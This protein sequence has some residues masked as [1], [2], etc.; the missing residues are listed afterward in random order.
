MSIHLQTY[1]GFSDGTSHITQNF[2]FVAYAIYS[3]TDELVSIHGIWLGQKTNN[4]EE[5][6]V[7]IE[8]L[9]NAI[10]FGIH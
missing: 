4:I 5:Y 2:S 8:L 1:I 7:V 6:S 9:S 10:S 3:P